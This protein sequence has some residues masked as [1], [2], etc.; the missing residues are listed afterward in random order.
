[1][2]GSPA[3]S[4]HFKVTQTIAR[5]CECGNAADP[6]NAGYDGVSMENLSDM[7]ICNCEPEL[8]SDWCYLVRVKYVR[9]EVSI[10]CCDGMIH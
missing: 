7:K 10:I 3:L 1:M 9:N 2:F 6:A 5:R 8:L 4:A